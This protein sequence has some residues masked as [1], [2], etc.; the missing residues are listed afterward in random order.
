MER[1]LP[2]KDDFFKWLKAHRPE[3]IIGFSDYHYHLNRSELDREMPYISLHRDNLPDAP[4]GFS[5]DAQDYARETVN[6]LHFCRR[7]YQWG[8]PK[9][10]IDHVIEPTWLEGN[11]LPMR[12][13][14]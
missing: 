9:H 11:T 8:I 13:A 6:L 10:R 7:T 2:W 5:P 4:S 12:E 1:L 3:V 14:A